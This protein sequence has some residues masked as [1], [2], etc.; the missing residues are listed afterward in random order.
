[1]KR[2]LQ[3]NLGL[4]RALAALLLI[5]PLA[6]SAVAIAHVPAEAHALTHPNHFKAADSAPCDFHSETFCQICRSAH[7]TSLASFGSGRFSPRD[8]V[9]TA[10]SFG[11]AE[12]LLAAEQRS[13]FGPRAPP[14]A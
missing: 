10:L 8:L 6:A 4:C 11:R 1:V 14:S 9:Y 13:P 2:T 3:H 5:Q 12:D 7:T